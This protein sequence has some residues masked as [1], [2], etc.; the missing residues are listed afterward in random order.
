MP[1]YA[2]GQLGG[3]NEDPSAFLAE[4]TMDLWPGQPGAGL[5]PSGTLALGPS[6]SLL[7]EASK[8]HFTASAAPS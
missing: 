6:S 2:G 7:P 3:G 4:F 5:L 8:G 1:G